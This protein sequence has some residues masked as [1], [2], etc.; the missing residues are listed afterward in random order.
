MCLSPWSVNAVHKLLCVIG[1][2]PS[3]GKACRCCTAVDLQCTY[4]FET[5]QVLTTTILVAHL[6]ALLFGVRGGF[7]SVV[8]SLSVLLPLLFGKGPRSSCLRLVGKGHETVEPGQASCLTGWG[9]RSLFGRDLG[10]G[11]HTRCWLVAPTA[12]LAGALEVL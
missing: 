11:V 8:T 12:C 9:T 6:N 4:L 3:D 5:Y 7:S 1:P 10:E 2:S